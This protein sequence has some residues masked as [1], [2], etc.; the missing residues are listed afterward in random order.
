MI[1][2]CKSDSNFL[3]LRMKSYGMTMQMEFFGGTV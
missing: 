3:S 1:T 2:S